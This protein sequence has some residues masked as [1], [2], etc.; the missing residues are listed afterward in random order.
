MGI[1]QSTCA[2]CKCDYEGEENFGH[3]DNNNNLKGK[4]KASQSKPFKI[5]DDSPGNGMN[6]SYGYQYLSNHT[7][8][9]IPEYQNENGRNN[10]QNLFIKHN[11]NNNS[12]NIK[13]QIYFSTPFKK[14]LDTK[15]Q[16]VI[17]IQA[18]IRGYQYRNIFP[19][20]KESLEI[21]LAKKIEC[22]KL[23][24][25]NNFTDRNF[26]RPSFN[27]NSYK[28]YYPSQT[29]DQLIKQFKNELLLPCKLL[30]YNDNQSYYIGSVNVLNQR[31]GQGVLIDNT[32]HTKSEGFWYKNKLTGWSRVTDSDGNISEGLFKGGLLNGKGEKYFVDGTV[33]KG[34]FVNGF[35][36]GEGVEENNEYLYKGEFYLDKKEGKGSHHYKLKNDLYIGEFK[37]G[38][39]TGN[40]KYIWSNSD[41]YEG[42][43]LRGKMHGKGKYLWADGDEYEG[44][45][46]D[47]LKE[48]DGMFKWSN[49]KV[50]KGKF[51]N[52]KPHGKGVFYSENKVY[53]VVF[54]DGKMTM[55]KEIVEH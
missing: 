16:K 31:N 40:G 52:G 44:D 35:R 7:N 20:I 2:N 23:R 55:S 41:V 49:G 15:E 24:F 34:D 29:V 9:D 1:A 13:K 53:D 39:I 12:V 18:V 38:N 42:E 32:T 43:F 46:V 8:T 19:N 10:Y 21:L 45:Y 51:V 25:E 33:Y 36:Q 26:I 30:I 3:F 48:G 28:K 27:I 14:Q 54:S 6:H 37:N 50:Y 17:F 47:G 4:S 11:T 5:I 22:I